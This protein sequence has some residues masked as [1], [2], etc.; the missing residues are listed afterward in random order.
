M[1][2]AIK[3]KRDYL[4]MLKGPMT[5]EDWEKALGALDYFSRFYLRYRC[6]EIASKMDLHANADEVVK[7]ADKFMDY[8]FEEEDDD[9]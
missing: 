4:E 7:R 6:I 3:E 2:A 8:I 9:D 1:N 5:N